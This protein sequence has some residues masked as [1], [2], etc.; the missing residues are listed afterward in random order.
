MGRSAD[1]DLASD[2][3]GR[4]EP[5]KHTLMTGRIV[6]EDGVTV[7]DCTILD[8]SSSGAHIRFPHGRSIPTRFH[9]INVRDRTAHDAKVVWRNAEHAGLLFE[10]S[11]T[12]S[13]SIPH[14]LSHLRKLWF[15]CATR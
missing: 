15:E 4:R 8:V 11:Y 5:R 13:G 12:L 10:A 9:L 2:R 3:N 14:H 6:H 7:L 1:S